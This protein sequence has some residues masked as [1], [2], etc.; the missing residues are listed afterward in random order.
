MALAEA[1]DAVTAPLMRF[2]E[3]ALLPAAEARD[4]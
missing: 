1:P 3:R 2:L 4:G